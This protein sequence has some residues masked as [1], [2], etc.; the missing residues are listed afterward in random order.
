MPRTRMPAEARK[1]EIVETVLAILESLPVEDLTTDRIA[2]EVG[3]SQAAIFR[4]FPTKNDLWLAV[5]TT[6][7]AR[8]GAKWEAALVPEAAP[9]ER[10]AAVL[11]AQLAL[12]EATPA[13][14]KLI[15]TVGR[16]TKEGAI[17]EVHMRIMTRLRAILLREIEAFMQ[18]GPQR[19]DIQSQDIADL[20][21]G[22]VQG[23]VLRW[24][25]SGHRFDLEREGARLIACQLGLL[26]QVKGKQP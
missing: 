12:I 5:L 26:Q 1:R 15:F 22:L 17:L 11:G 10:V 20:L 16:L 25:L 4:H 23:L 8:A 21:L 2:L 18:E 7:E 14:P 6:V 3:I 19:P 13:V 24:Q 9:L